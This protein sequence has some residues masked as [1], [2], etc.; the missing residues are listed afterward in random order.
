MKK[1]RLTLIKTTYI[2]IKVLALFIIILSAIAYYT[3]VKVLNEVYDFEK[4]HFFIFSFIS[5]VVF[6]MFL[7][8]YLSLTKEE[9]LLNKKITNIKKSI[10]KHELDIEK[11]RS[12]KDLNIAEATII[13]KEN[14]P[15]LKFDKSDLPMK[16]EELLEIDSNL[17]TAMVLGNSYKQ[18]VK[19]FFKD[20]VSL[21]CVETTIWFVGDNHVTLKEGINIPKNKIYKVII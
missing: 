10:I 14:I 21:R 8:F 17:K 11:M 16:P 6:F 7:K 15:S 19:V 5:I 12:N 2:T 3:P 13:A 20:V 9:G 18:K 4:H 1:S